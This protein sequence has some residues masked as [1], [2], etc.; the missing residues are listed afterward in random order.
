MTSDAMTA[1]SPFEGEPAREHLADLRRLVRALG[2]PADPQGL[3]EACPR[4]VSLAESLHDQAAQAEGWHQLGIGHARVGEFTEAREAYAMAVQLWQGLGNV[5]EELRAR[6]GLTNALELMGEPHD[7]LE[8]ARVVAGAED[9]FLQCSGLIAIGAVQHLIGEFG[10]ALAHIQKAEDVLLASPAGPRQ[11]AYLQA[12]LAGNRA[13]VYLDRGDLEAA[14][15]SSNRMA[16]AAD[17]AEER[18]QKLEALLNIGLCK[19]RMGDLA[20]AW[21]Y[22][23]QAHQAASLGG[24]R[25][26]EA[27]ANWALSEWFCQAGLC[28]SAIGHA[29]TSRQLAAASR[30]RF[31]ELHACLCLASAYLDSGT[32]EAGAEAVQSAHEHARQLKATCHEIAATVLEARLTAAR[33]DLASSARALEGSVS[34]ARDVGS[35]GLALSAGTSLARVLLGQGCAAEARAEAIRVAEATDR[36]GARNELWQAWHVAGSASIALGDIE[37]GLGHYRAAIDVV[38]RMWWP[39]WRIGFAQVQ[40]V[41]QTLVDLY[42]DHLRAA[43]AC[44]RSDEVARVLS[45]SPWPFL[46]ERWEGDSAAAS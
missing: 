34:R 9:W 45:L 2:G 43:T 46:R 15:D 6:Q 42:L 11:T 10:D 29:I 8:Q 35:I 4:L 30:T 37:E 32:P 18:G 26:R 19:G 20:E 22:L 24:D 25:L 12:Y 23:S 21:Q 13:N 16:A 39:L 28:H 1:E 7:A 38:E 17:L 40:D 31:A 27:T 33:G 5:D 3:I 41:K 44:G 14:L 36:L